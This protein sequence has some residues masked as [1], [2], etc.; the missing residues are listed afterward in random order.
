MRRS[1]ARV[2]ARPTKRGARPRPRPR[3]GGRA[4]TR[5]S[6]AWARRALPTG[7]EHLA[8]L[9]RRRRAARRPPRDR[10][11][12]GGRGR[13]RARRGDARGR[14]RRRRR[15]GAPPSSASAPASRRACCSSSTSATPRRAAAARAAGR[16]AARRLRA[17]ARSRAPARRSDACSPAS[18]SSRAAGAPRWSSR[19]RSPDLVVVTAAGDRFGG[20]GPWRVGGE[21]ATVTQSRVRGGARAR[22]R[23]GGRTRGRRGARRARARAGLDAARARTPPSCLALEH[24]RTMVQER[25]A[26]V[27]ARLA[28]RDR[29]EQAQAERVRAAL[30]GRRRGVPAARHPARSVRAAHRGAARPA[31]RR[32][33]A[34]GRARARV[35]RTARQSA[36]RARRGSSASSPR[37]ASAPQRA[38]IERGR[39]APAAGDRGRAAA[40]RVRRA[41]PRPRSTPRRP[42]LPRARRSRVA[43]ASSS[44]SCASW[45]RSTRSRSRST[46]RCRS[47]TD[48]LQE[49]LE[50]V[51]SSRREL[52]AR[53][54]GRR[55]EIVTVFE[56]A[57]ADVQEHFERLFSTLFPGGSGRL[58]L[59]DPDDLLNTGI[60]MEAR[61]S[62][63]N[64]RRLSLL[65]GGER[66]LTALAFLFAVFR[67]RP[68]PFYL[69]GRGRGRARRRE[70][71]P[72][73]RPRA[74]VPRRGAARRRVAPE[75][76]D[77]GGRLPLRRVDAARA[78]RAAS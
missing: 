75:A 24:R 78:G 26:T 14:G 28:A 35:G 9:R 62:G 65:S 53:D 42:T 2:C 33:A 22:G 21:A 52:H 76:H 49:Q 77:G 16:A 10:A 43:R 20:S 50:D 41:S 38:E 6:S 39:G 67:A 37:C 8:G 48:F 71:A 7:V 5:S 25:L 13:R 31:A 63:K 68:S 45:V 73:P 46:T 18:C 51:K 17:H 58:L 69:H 61:P 44:A 70:P 27:E 72:L 55:P 30:L 59:T 3:A 66:S 34:A 64:V 57:F 54:P 56:D 29:D 15:D 12:C 74:R 11:G 36:D 47:V 40:H 19:S 60:E 23:G 4:P 32:A 1:R